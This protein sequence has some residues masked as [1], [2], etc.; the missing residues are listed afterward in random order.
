[1][2][3]AAA[4]LYAGALKLTEAE[5]R[6]LSE[7]VAATYPIVLRCAICGGEISAAW[8]RTCSA[9]CRQGF[10]RQHGQAAPTRTEPVVV[11]SVS[12][13]SPLFPS[14]GISVL[15]SI[16]SI[17]PTPAVPAVLIEEKFPGSSNPEPLTTVGG[18]TSARAIVAAER[19][20]GVKVVLDAFHA[21][22]VERHGSKPNITGKDA[23]IAKSLVMAH[24]VK[25][26]L[27][28]MGRMLESGDEFIASRPSFGT[29]SSQW[30][31]LVAG[32]PKSSIFFLILM[33]LIIKIGSRQ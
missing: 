29:L 2:T 32:P 13:Q 20:A 22:F 8:A 18:T 33:I 15:P 21:A 4:A 9:K 17:A 24:G 23:A 3:P 16:V 1:M 19:E 14:D 11:L 5:R 25:V 6:W 31:A 26:V 28:V 27:D 7:Q 30:N 10:C 12:P